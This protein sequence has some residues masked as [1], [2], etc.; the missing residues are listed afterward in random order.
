MIKNG[1]KVQLATGGP[2]LIVQHCTLPAAGGGAPVQVDCE[3]VRPGTNALLTAVNPLN[4]GAPITL[5]YEAF[6]LPQ[7]TI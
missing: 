1:A 6:I 4:P 3:F 5:A 2:L 7:I